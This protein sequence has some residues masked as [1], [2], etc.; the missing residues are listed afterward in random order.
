MRKLVMIACLL[1]AGIM[2]S[3]AGIYDPSDITEIMERV[4]IFSAT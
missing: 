3:D 2:Y 1:A 4:C